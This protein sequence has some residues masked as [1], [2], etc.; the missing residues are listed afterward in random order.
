M[1][2]YSAPSC[3]SCRRVQFDST[4]QLRSLQTK[5]GINR[6]LVFIERKKTKSAR[7]RGVGNQKTQVTFS[8]EFLAKIETRLL[9]W[10]ASSLITAPSFFLQRLFCLNAFILAKGNLTL[11]GKTKRFVLFRIGHLTSLFSL[12]SSRDPLTASSAYSLLIFLRQNAFPAGGLYSVHILALDALLAVVQSIEG[13]C[14]SQLLNT[15][16]KAI[17]EST[18]VVAQKKKKEK[19]GEKRTLFHISVVCRQKENFAINCTEI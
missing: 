16:E 5:S 11:C 18:P 8:V 19:T 6:A 7:K 17:E 2:L 15:A 14:H 9:W 12:S 3:L 4:N 10:K 13:H 1:P